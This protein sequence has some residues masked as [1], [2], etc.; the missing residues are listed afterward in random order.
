MNDLA[1]S[2][3]QIT[4]SEIPK[5]F[6]L[7]NI[8]KM[9]VEMQPPHEKILSENQLAQRYKVHRLTS[10]Q[11]ITELVNEGI[12]YREQGRGTFI[13]ERNSDF[14]SNTSK[15]VAC[16]FRKVQGRRSD[17]NFFLELFEGFEN[18]IEQK[19][20]FMLYRSFDKYT[21]TEEELYLSAKKIV[22]TD[23]AGLVVDRNVPDTVIER[24]LPL[25]KPVV[26]LNR[27]TYVE[28][29]YSVMPDIGKIVALA[30]RYLSDLGHKRIAFIY[31]IGQPNQMKM[32]SILQ[33]SL[34]DYGLDESD[35]KIIS[36]HELNIDGKV[37]QNATE[38]AVK[39]HNSTAIFAG[40]DWIATH[41][42]AQL[43][44]MNIKIPKDISVISTGD[45]A[46]A[47]QMH[48]PLTTVRIDAETIGRTAA[49]TIIHPPVKKQ[50]LVRPEFIKRFSCN[51][52]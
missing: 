8:L 21:A 9:M 5:Y 30:M 52:R 24:L 37:Y 38:I 39:E 17:D 34:P 26:V 44:K 48:P 3:N 49:E 12:L 41:V 23:I 50:V 29:V 33:N 43:N 13:A 27:E 14:A 20:S 6:Q 28:G 11:A 1:D 36:T 19:N 16:L 4:D 35:V 22:K 2:V 31:D 10:R 51:N 42:Y 47:A 25:Q 45:Y 7:K 18:K 32:C 15:N 40:F 46:M